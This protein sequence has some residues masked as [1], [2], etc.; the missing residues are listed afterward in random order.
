V[1]IPPIGEHPL[2][3]SSWTPGLA[4]DWADSVDQR[5]QL[6]DVVAM[7]AGQADREWYPAR[8]GDQVVL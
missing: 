6:G 4:G 8:I 5:Q 3:T 2:G 7:P 1:V